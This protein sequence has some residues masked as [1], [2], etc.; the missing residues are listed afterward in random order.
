MQNVKAKVNKT[1]YS[2]HRVFLL[3]SEYRS[4]HFRNIG[5]KKR[6]IMNKFHIASKCL[7]LCLCLDYDIHWCWA[8]IAPIISTLS[9]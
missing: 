6:L 7:L 2:V 5:N 3:N 8:P 9:G 1:S 4:G